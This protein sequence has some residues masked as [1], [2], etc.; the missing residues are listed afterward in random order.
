MPPKATA[1][2]PRAQAGQR[3]PLAALSINQ[4]GNRPNQ[5]PQSQLHPGAAAGPAKSKSAYERVA[6]RRQFA[7]DVIYCDAEP[8]ITEDSI[9]CEICLRPYKIRENGSFYADQQTSFVKEHGSVFD[10]PLLRAGQACRDGKVCKKLGGS[11]PDYASMCAHVAERLRSVRRSLKDNKLDDHVFPCVIYNCNESLT[12]HQNLVAHVEADHAVVP[13]TNLV[14]GF[15]GQFTHRPSFTTFCPKVIGFHDQ[16][17]HRLEHIHKGDFGQYASPTGAWTSCEFFA[18]DPGAG[19]F[20]AVCGACTQNTDKPNEDWYRIAEPEDLALHLLTEH[21]EELLLPRGDG[22][23]RCPGEA[24]SALIL[25]GARGV[26]NHVYEKR[27]V[28]WQAQ[29]PKVVLP[30]LVPAP[31]SAS[32][33]H[34]PSSAAHPPASNTSALHASSLSGPSSSLSSRKGKGKAPGPPTLLNASTDLSS[35]GVASDTGTSTAANVAGRSSTANV[36]SSMAANVAAT[37]P[38][39]TTSIAV[40]LPDNVG[41]CDNLFDMFE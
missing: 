3:T 2:P 32:A 30:P 33:P 26:V 17:Q 35:V 5:P 7:S 36:A 34:A 29:H 18:P 27:K 10:C 9:Y 19:E 21:V 22:T 39:A 1:P 4:V 20:F 12:G 24:C 38:A 31:A 37:P 15:D 6:G 41:H 16:V 8:T 14:E 23:Y 25:P 11:Y 40:S 13:L 28:E